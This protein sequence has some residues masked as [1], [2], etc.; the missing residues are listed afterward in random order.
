MR[1]F[2]IWLSFTFVALVLGPLLFG[3][4]AAA[5][6]KPPVPATPPLEGTM[7]G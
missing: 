6:R 5:A 3:P 4:G 7:A 1:R 2:P